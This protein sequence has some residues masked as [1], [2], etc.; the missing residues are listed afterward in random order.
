MYFYI[1]FFSKYSTPYLEYLQF[2]K[3]VALKPELTKF[4]F[5]FEKTKD[6]G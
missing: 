6:E 5:D 4:Y 1:P 2:F 3:N